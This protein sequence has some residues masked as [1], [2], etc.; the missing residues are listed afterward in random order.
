[1]P[2]GKIPVLYR[3]PG[4]AGGTNAAFDGATKTCKYACSGSGRWWVSDAVKQFYQCAAGRQALLERCPE[5]FRFN[6][7]NAQCVLA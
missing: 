3:C 2:S 1:M 5:E 4:E 7:A 6:S